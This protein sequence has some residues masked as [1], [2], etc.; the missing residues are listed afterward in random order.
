MW[1]HRRMSVNQDDSAR[2]RSPLRL[3]RRQDGKDDP[4]GHG[5]QGPGPAGAAGRRAPRR[6]RRGALAPRRTA[7][8]HHVPPAGFADAG[9]VCGLRAGRPPLP[10]GPAHLPAR[11]AR[12]QPPRFAGTALPVLRRVTEQTGEATILVRPRRPPPPH[13][14]QGGRPADLPRHQRSRPPRRPAHDVRGQGAGGFCRGFGACERL[15]EELRAGTPHRAHHHGPCRVPGGDRE[16]PPAGIC[17]DG[18]GERERH[19]RRGCAAA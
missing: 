11:P 3:R 18:R 14:Q 10:P 19:A 2:R 7:L 17:R 13:G 4:D 9:R 5:G 8:Q 15:L 12:L 1:Q 6:Q 16:G